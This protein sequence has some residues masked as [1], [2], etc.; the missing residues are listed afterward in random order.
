M[1]YKQY[2]VSYYRKANNTE[3]RVRVYAEDEAQ[4]LRIIQTKFQR[5]GEG[6]YNIVKE[7]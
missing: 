4:A 7:N 6:E 5:F 2:T 1:N 3:Y